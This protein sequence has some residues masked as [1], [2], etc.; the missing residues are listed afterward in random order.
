[1]STPS[2]ILKRQ[3][4]TVPSLD[5]SRDV[6]IQEEAGSIDPDTVSSS[7]SRLLGALF[8]AELLQD[9]SIDRLRN[10]CQ[11]RLSMR[12]LPPSVDSARI[13]EQFQNATLLYRGSENFYHSRDLLIDWESQRV[14]SEV[15]RIAISRHDS[16]DVRIQGESGIF[17]VGKC[18]YP[19]KHL[20]VDQG[21]TNP[22]TRSS[23]GLRTDQGASWRIDQELSGL[24]CVMNE[25]AH[26]S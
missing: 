11:V 4:L 1:M 13:L 3:S 25:L 6:I 22:W 17:T 21:F 19:L 7:A 15:L 5:P 8:Y 2:S 16:I 23:D 12:V 18:P 26:L 14:R 10:Y 24:Y 9:L 20:I